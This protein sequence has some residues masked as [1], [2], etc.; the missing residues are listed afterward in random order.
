M[1]KIWKLDS[2]IW[3][4]FY[5]TAPISPRIVFANRPDLDQIVPNESIFLIGLIVVLNGLQSSPFLTELTCWKTVVD[6]KPSH[7]GCLGR[8]RIGWGSSAYTPLAESSRGRR[9]KRT[10]RG[11]PQTEVFDWLMFFNM[12][13]KSSR[14]LFRYRIWS[15]KI[16]DQVLSGPN[17]PWWNGHFT[18]NLNFLH[19][20][21]T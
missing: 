2:K 14:S 17:N 4:Q 13:K 11:R 9:I 1:N 7:R 6:Q 8:L 10:F 5:W 21:I 20:I 12:C 15:T 3:V 18:Q 16:K 19:L